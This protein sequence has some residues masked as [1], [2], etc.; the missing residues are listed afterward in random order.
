MYCYIQYNIKTYVCEYIIV[1]TVS[2]AFPI[3][4]GA[5]KG[6]IRPSL[7]IYWGGLTCTVSTLPTKVFLYRKKG[8]NCTKLW[9]KKQQTPANYYLLSFNGTFLLKLRLDW[10][11]IDVH[12]G[13]IM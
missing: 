13:I 4:L 6:L 2:K 7:A 5:E 10:E 8:H 3:V 9:T 12:K 1:L 11:N